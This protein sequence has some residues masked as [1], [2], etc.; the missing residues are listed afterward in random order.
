MQLVGACFL[1][2]WTEM[3]RSGAVQVLLDRRDPRKEILLQRAP[4]PFH[5]WNYYC[6]STMFVS[7]LSWFK[8]R[9]STELLRDCWCNR[10]VA[11]ACAINE[12]LKDRVNMIHNIYVPDFVPLCPSSQTR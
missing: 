9:G 3:A 10:R 1:H 12:K 8:L 11:M 5:R 4:P 7:K 2:S 6:T